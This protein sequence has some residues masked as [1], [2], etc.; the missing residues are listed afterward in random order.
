ME[1]NPGFRQC[2][3]AAPEFPIKPVNGQCI[4]NQFKGVKKNVVKHGRHDHSAVFLNPSQ[5]GLCPARRVCNRPRWDLKITVKV[6]RQSCSI[7]LPVLT[8]STFFTQAMLASGQNSPESWKSVGLRN[9]WGCCQLTPDKSTF[10]TGVP[11]YQPQ[12]TVSS[13][14][15]IYLNLLYFLG[16]P[17][18]KITSLYYLIPHILW[19]TQLFVSCNFMGKP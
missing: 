12:A 10:E 14:I 18:W 6:S 3:V 9:S 5:D 15:S 19:I 7:H 4:L 8:L 17:A 11:K 13:A 2:I 16:L 1:I